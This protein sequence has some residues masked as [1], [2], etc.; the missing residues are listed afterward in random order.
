VNDIPPSQRYLKRGSMIPTPVRHLIFSPSIFLNHKILHNSSSPII[1][2]FIQPRPKVPPHYTTSIP[3]T[4]IISHAPN[5]QFKQ[6]SK[7]SSQST[8]SQPHISLPFSSPAAMTDIPLHSTSR[9]EQA[10]AESQEFNM[11]GGCIPIP[12]GKDKMIPVPCV[13]M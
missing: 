8:R 4:K 10:E 12:C 6:S 11:R 13:V 9:N 5:S 3:Q 1:F 2:F 7:M